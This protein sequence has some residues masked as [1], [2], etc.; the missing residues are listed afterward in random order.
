[1]PPDGKYRASNYSRADGIHQSA[2]NYARSTPNGDIWGIQSRENLIETVRCMMFYGYNDGF[3][4]DVAL[5][6][7]MTAAEYRQVLKH[8]QGLDD[9]MFPYTNQLGEKHWKK[10]LSPP[11]QAERVLFLGYQS[12]LL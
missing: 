11:N 8:T 9:Y 12:L 7:S 6:N 4:C 5:I 10:A 1:M 3:L 2:K